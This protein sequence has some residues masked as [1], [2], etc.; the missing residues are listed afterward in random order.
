MKRFGE[1][2]KEFRESKELPLRV[3]S[4]YLDIDQAILSKIERG[5]R[6][7]NRDLVIKLA[8]YFGADRNNFLV[9][10]LSDK[11][12]LEL[13]YEET[14]LKAL[15]LAEE[16][17]RYYTKNSSPINVI[18]ALQKTLNKDGRVNSAWLF[19]S[20]ARGEDTY[21]SDID[22]MVELNHDKKY[23]MFDLLDLEY[24]LGKPINRKV[25]LVEK[26]YLKGFSL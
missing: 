16:K 12:V 19:G 14:A 25:D 6:K 7:P 3:V 23:S 17:V 4:A 15:Q 10:W 13:E 26:G 20:V 21:K 24:Q 5:I 2:I 18:D 9:A 11:L 8:T 1:L 22:L